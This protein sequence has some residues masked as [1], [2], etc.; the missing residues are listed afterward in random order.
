M[1]FEKSFRV[2]VDLL[3]AVFCIHILVPCDIS[4]TQCQHLLPLSE[5]KLPVTIT[6]SATRFQAKYSQRS[7][8]QRFVFSVITAHGIFKP[9]SGAGLKGIQNHSILC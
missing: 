4:L 2:F 9:Q 8:V 5:D 7:F 3:P 1:S 6:A